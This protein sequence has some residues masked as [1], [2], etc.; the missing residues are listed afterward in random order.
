[1]PILQMSKAGLWGE[2]LKVMEKK[3]GKE[4]NPGLSGLQMLS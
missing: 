2:L 3:G 1:M 4:L